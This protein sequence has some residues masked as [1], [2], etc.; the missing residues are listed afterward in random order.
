[1]PEQQQ[2]QQEQKPF[3]YELKKGSNESL[4]DSLILTLRH[5]YKHRREARQ[6]SDGTK[7]IHLAIQELRTYRENRQADPERHARLDQQYIKASYETILSPPECQKRIRN[8]KIADHA[9]YELTQ[10]KWISTKTNPANERGYPNAQQ[11][12]LFI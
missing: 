2:E 11:T 10:R 9:E 4:E 7:W 1:M 8:D 5:R 6:R 3:L 12:D